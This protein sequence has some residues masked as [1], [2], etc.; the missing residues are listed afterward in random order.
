VA[1]PRR[2]RDRAS[3]L[4]VARVGEQVALA[5]ALL[6]LARRLSV[7]D[8]GVV[9]LVFAFQTLAVTAS[10]YG[11]GLALLRTPPEVA[12]ARASLDR[13][14]RG[15]ATIVVAG[16]V[17]AGV[18]GAADHSR[19][20]VL[21]LVGGLIWAT[22]AEAY[23]RKAAALRL[24]EARRVAVS[25]VGASALLLAVI[26][27]AARGDAAPVVVAGA[28]VAKSVVELLVSSAAV[29]RSFTTVGADPSPGW[30]W[31]SQVLSF[32][33]ANVDYVVVALVLG[34]RA[35]GLYSLAFRIAGLLPSQVSFVVSRVGT[36]DLARRSPGERPEATRALLR[37]LFLAGLCVAAFGLAV[38]PFVGD[39]LG[40]KW[41]DAEPLV[42]L[43]AVSAPWRLILPVA[44]ISALVRDRARDLVRFEGSRLVLVVTLLTVGA[45]VNLVWCA[46]LA[47]VA[48]VIGAA[49]AHL[50][51]P[52]RIAER[53]ST[54]LAVVSVAAVAGLLAAGAMV[55]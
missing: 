20:A 13:C 14:R 38:A 42:A 22:S 31:G 18:L 53:P 46:T 39:A 27:L 43:L 33:I 52:L 10:D 26:V 51:P 5:G 21:V 24:D 2:A 23:I 37:T 12:V 55:A 8:F 36:V 16:A 30:V 50:L 35:L 15:N 41:D 1:D 19:A 9:S 34:S 49:S 11:V 29:R 7:T 6:I 3:V 44:G 32:A 40:H 48:L 54:V 45:T 47:S 17:L 25:E 28:F 4:A